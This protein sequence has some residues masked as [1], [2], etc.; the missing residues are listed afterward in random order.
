MRSPTPDLAFVVRSLRNAAHLPVA[1]MTADA[2]TTWG[3]GEYA[4]IAERLEPAANAVVDLAGVN[5]SDR[6]L[7]VATGTGNAALRAASRG[8]NVVGLDF[9]PRLLDIARARAHS[10]N[11]DVDWVQADIES[12]PLERAAF[13]VVV[14]AFGVMYSPDHDAAAAALARCCAPGARLALAAWMPGSFMP[15]MGAALAP[16]L[17]PPPPGGAPPSRWGDAAAVAELLGRHGIDTRT[18]TTESL[19]LSFRDRAAAVDFLIRTAG[20]VV[21]EQPRLQREG[22]WEQLRGD[23]AELVAARDEGGDS[24]ELRCEYLVVVAERA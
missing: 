24:V 22:R 10:A 19:A 23:L 3:V 16:Y 2:A 9:E 1:A 20:H 18:S 7:D 15:A 21:S 12:A 17:P 13:S 8:A 4:L 11:L 5:D 6:V 14:S